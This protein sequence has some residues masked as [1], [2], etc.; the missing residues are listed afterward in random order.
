MQFDFNS[1]DVKPIET[2]KKKEA[3]LIGFDEDSPSKT[4]DSGLLDLGESKP[5]E[6]PKETLESLLFTEE[7]APLIDTNST[8][9]APISHE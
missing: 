7:P 4:V 2:N 9:V 3:D 6:K 8:D 1:F 5:V